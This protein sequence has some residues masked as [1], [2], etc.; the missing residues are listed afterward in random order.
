MIISSL[1]YISYIG[2]TLTCASLL[3]TGYRRSRLPL[4][5]YVGFCFLFLSLNSILAFVDL[6][7]LP[8]VDLTFGRY[9]STLVALSILFVGLIWEGE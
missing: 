9:A 6:L 5:G 7:L 8:D 3:L 2:L 1:I 4:L